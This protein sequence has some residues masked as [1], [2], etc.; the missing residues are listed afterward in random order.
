[1]ERQEDIFDKY[2]SAAK[3]QAAEAG[4][5]YKVDFELTRHCPSTCKICFSGSTLSGSTMSR[6]VALAVIDDIATLG[7]RQI[8]WE[9]GESLLVPYLFDLIIYA[10][11]LGLRNGIVSGGLP[12]AKPATARRVGQAYRDRWLNEFIIHIDTIDPQNFARL[13]TNP[14]E[15]SQRIRGY[16]NLLEAGFPRERVMPCITLTRYSAETIEE[17]IDWYLDEMGVRFIELTV[18][19][20][21]GAGSLSQAELEPSLSQVRRAFEY[22]AR[23][24]GSPNWLRIGS[25]ECSTIQCRTDFYL[26]VDGLVKP[27]SQIPDSFAVGNIHQERLT[28]IFARHREAIALKMPVKGRC[29]ACENNDICRGCRAAAYWYLGDIQ[30]PD[31]KCRLNPEA[32]EAYLR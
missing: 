1:M 7:F 13:H 11:G 6:H 12:L 26:T 3:F 20:P 5:V 8:M 15:L 29:A 18:F 30:G 4:A 10:A 16:R 32:R 14:K 23:R 28:E 25:T 22:R 2:I 31:P 19:K 17:T 24:L 27:C 9:G 21:M